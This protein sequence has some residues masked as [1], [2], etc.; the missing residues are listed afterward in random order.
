MSLSAVFYTTHIK[1][2]I[3][4]VPCFLRI[5]VL[6]V[7]CFV[8][9]YVYIYSCPNIINKQTKDGQN[10]K[11][12]PSYGTDSRFVIEKRTEFIN[13]QKYTH[14]VIASIIST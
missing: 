3:H 6:S 14:E 8:I 9:F 1:T 2:E 12:M 13:A 5:N 11:R 7:N 10:D 4:T